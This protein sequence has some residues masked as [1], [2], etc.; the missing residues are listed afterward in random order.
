MQT[1]ILRCNLN[2]CNVDGTK[3]M[4]LEKCCLTRNEQTGVISPCYYLSVKITE[5]GAPTDAWNK[6]KGFVDHSRR[7]ESSGL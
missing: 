2:H 6:F 5:E 3:E 1:M 7:K 4:Q